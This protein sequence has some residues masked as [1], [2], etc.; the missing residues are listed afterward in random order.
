MRL[1]ATS[2]LRV[3]LRAK[4]PFFQ[5]WG[6][7][8]LVEQLYDKCRGIADEA[9]DIIEEACEDDTHLHS[10]VQIRPSLLHMG[11]KGA[12]LLTR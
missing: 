1:Y 8:L 12:L 10:L 11:D 7:E 4:I 5:I 3:L 6:M 2:H 9:V